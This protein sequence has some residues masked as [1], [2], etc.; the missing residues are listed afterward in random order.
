MS[1][2]FPE[3]AESH[4]T[5]AVV[6]DCGRSVNVTRSCTTEVFEKLS[7]FCGVMIVQVPPGSKVGEALTVAVGVGVEVA[8]AVAVGVEVAF[9]V[10]VAVGITGAVVGMF[11]W[12][13]CF[14]CKHPAIAKESITA[15]ARIRVFFT[16]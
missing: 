10:A 4:F 6:T 13:S 11:P 12:S 8:P 3:P 5:T 1:M 9:A 2:L 16:S 14:S 15:K 7:L